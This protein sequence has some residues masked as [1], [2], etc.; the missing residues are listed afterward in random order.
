MVPMKK[1]KFEKSS[2]IAT[3]LYT[4]SRKYGILER[5]VLC[6]SDSS[7]CPLH[8]LQVFRSWS[9]TPCRIARILKACRISG[10]FRYMKAVKFVY[11]KYF[12]K[13]TGNQGIIHKAFFFIFFNSPKVISG[14]ARNELSTSKGFQFLLVQMR[15]KFELYITQWW[16]LDICFKNYKKK[17]ILNT[18]IRQWRVL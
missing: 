6:N 14:Q 4:I 13:V 15:W 10:I 1:F 5:V 16:W 12:P 9:K 2:S 17:K 7:L 3:L 18:K 8:F 11:Y